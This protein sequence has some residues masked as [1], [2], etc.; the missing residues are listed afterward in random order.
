[1]PSTDWRQQR[2]M[3]RSGVQQQ[4]LQQEHGAETAC[5]GYALLQLLCKARL[6]TGA[7]GTELPPAGTSLSGP[8]RPAWKWGVVVWVSEALNMR[9]TASND[10]HQMHTNGP[11][12]SRG[13][14][15]VG[16]GY[17][18]ASGPPA[19]SSVTDAIGTLHNAV[20]GS[21]Q[22]CSGAAGRAGWGSTQVRSMHVG[23]VRHFG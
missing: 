18:G 8:W 10:S 1:M 7:S 3:V 23:Y 17:S 11:L 22:L 21:S 5:G 16:P 2:G 20:K 15:T 6:A 13:T 4:L 9:S 12:T 19:G 14:H